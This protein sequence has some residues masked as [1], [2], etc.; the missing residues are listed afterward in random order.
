MRSTI[1]STVLASITQLSNA[2]PS[3]HESQWQNLG[4]QQLEHTEKRFV[5]DPRQPIDITESHSFKPPGRGDQRGPC[6][7]LN[8]LAN[9][10]YISRNGIT[11]FSEVV[12][13]INQVLGMSVELAL[14]LGV[15]GTVWTGNPLSLNPGFSIGG[16]SNGDGSDNLLGNLVGLLGKPRGLQGSH[17]WIESDASLTRNDL[18][19]TGNA[20]TMNMTLF[21]DIHDRADTRG[22]I[23]MDALADQAARRFENSVA[24]NP[25]FYYGPITGMVSRNAGYFFLGRLLSNHTAENPEGELTQDV[26]RKFFAVYQNA[27]GSLEY[28]EGHETIP[29]NWYRAPI[30]YGLAQLN[31]DIVSWVMK[32]PRLGSIGGNTGTVN[33]FTGLDMGNVSGGVLNTATLLEKNN[34]LCFTFELMK[35][36]MPNSLSPLL[37]AIGKPLQLVAD[38]LSAP[39]LSLACPAW[40]DMTENGD[41]LWTEI[42]NKFPGASKA[43]SSL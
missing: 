37:S 12:T 32:H 1:L 11:S 5:I 17:N 3:I 13:A 27:D 6:P 25:D 18:Y 43:G 19:L 38:T 41:L 36:F 20:W 23:P 29:E 9:H 8:A 35:T 33:S 22:V 28:R 42:Q 34:L 16:T 15:M 30:E 40:Q 14:I 10:G 7:G 31:I 21:R 24:T 4:S 2:F 39:L 26:L